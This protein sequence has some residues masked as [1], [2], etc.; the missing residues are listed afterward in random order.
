M[1]GG[2]LARAIN[3]ERSGRPEVHVIEE[4]GSANEQN[5]WSLL[6]GQGPIASASGI[7][8]ASS[9][10]VKKVLGNPSPP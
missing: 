1:K 3:D 5:F 7:A 4:I 2:Q 9:S 8:I 6:G 10:L